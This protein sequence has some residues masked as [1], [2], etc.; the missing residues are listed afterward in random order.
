M[1]Y[2]DAVRYTNHRLALYRKG[3][4]D[5]RDPE[6]KSNDRNSWMNAA[7][8][9]RAPPRIFMPGIKKH[10]HILNRIR[11]P[12]RERWQ[13]YETRIRLVQSWFG[14]MPHTR[15]QFK[16][17]LGAGGQG[18]AMQFKYTDPEVYPEGRDFVLKTSIESWES[19]SLRREEDWALVRTNL[20]MRIRVEAEPQPRK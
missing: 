6:E 8:P 18:L 5:Y 15:F 12:A 19:R 11:K 14:V 20:G 4:Y 17:N 10:P 2:G 1:D 3:R 16:R 13:K 7:L 9:M